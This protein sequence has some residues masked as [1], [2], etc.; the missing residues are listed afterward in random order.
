MS[1]QSVI[2]LTASA[3]CTPLLG[4]GFRCV[5]HA[6]IHIFD[7]DILLPALLG[8]C[9]HLRATA[10]TPTCTSTGWGTR[11]SRCRE[12]R[13]QTHTAPA[14]R[15]LLAQGCCCEAP[16]VV[17]QGL[18]GSFWPEAGASGAR[19]PCRTARASSCTS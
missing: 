10:R 16:S 14:A 12:A 17:R 8:C 1:S 6:S 13:C 19:G 18:Q 15:R 4:W 2:P 11:K 7:S 9:P 3:P 5:R